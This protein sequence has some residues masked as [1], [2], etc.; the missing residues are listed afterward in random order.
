MIHDPAMTGV[1]AMC[2]NE[3]LHTE[4]EYHQALQG[5]SL[6]E[7]DKRMFKINLDY[8]ETSLGIEKHTG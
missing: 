6:Q 4:I 5:N 7:E 2:R 3:R 1:L 8:L